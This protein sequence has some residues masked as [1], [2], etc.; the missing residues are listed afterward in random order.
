M[1]FPYSFPF[2]F[3]GPPPTTDANGCWIGLP[4]TFER[5]LLSQQDAYPLE[6]LRL[7]ALY[8]ATS[9]HD[10]IQSARAL[11][12]MAFETEAGTVLVK[13]VELSPDVLQTKVCPRRHYIDVDSD[14]RAF[15][16]LFEP[17][18]D[19]IGKKIPDPYVNFL[20]RF[21]SSDYPRYRVSA[22]AAMLCLAAAKL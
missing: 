18:L 20:R 7:R 9:T 8:A 4:S 17:A 11:I 13:M 19:E 15:K 10:F 21:L 1:P 22:T 12:Q 14:L 3:G 6:Q 16:F 5:Q 2:F